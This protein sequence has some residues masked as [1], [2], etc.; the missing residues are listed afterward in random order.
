MSKAEDNVTRIDSHLVNEN[1]PK[2][3][4]AGVVIDPGPNFR[5]AVEDVPVPQPGKRDTFKA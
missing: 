1:I 2:T 5:V 4:K 3:C